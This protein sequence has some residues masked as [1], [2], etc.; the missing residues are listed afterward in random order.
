V[1][2]E[3]TILDRPEPHTQTAEMPRKILITGGSGL[4]G[5]A[6]RQC[7]PETTSLFYTYLSDDRP[8]LP[9]LGIRLDLRDPEAVR[10]TLET[11]RPKVV[12]HAAA[13]MVAEDFQAVIVEGSRR[14]ARSANA[15]GAGLVHISTDMVF[16]GDH[17]P[18]AETATVAPITAYGRAKATAETLVQEVHGG[19]VVIR[20]SLL[21][22]LEPP[23]ARTQR[24][25]DSVKSRE[26]VRLFTDEIRCPA[27][28]GDLAH[29]IAAV[30]LEGFSDDGT[31][32][33][34]MPS[35][36]HL[37][38]PSALTR[39]QFETE[40]LD[41]LGVTTAGIEK[42]TIRGLGLK[43]PRDLRLSRDLTPARFVDGIRSPAEVIQT[44][45]SQTRSPSGG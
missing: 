14:V 22:S 30:V 25:I 2:P 7:F 26:K 19:P 29:A 18:Y 41:S 10:S 28:V 9:G 17:A 3:V 1:S 12:I 33:E 20:T 8:S 23:D 42:A 13:S 38:G 11:L 44:Y 32:A 6:L 15:I 4:L 37:V 24:T 31:R 36:L 43:R 45:R 40:L 39:Y 16:D 35:I 21:F 5:R 34:T 27:E